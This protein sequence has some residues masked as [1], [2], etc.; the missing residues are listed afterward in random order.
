MT[1]K[2]AYEAPKLIKHQRLQKVTL[3]TTPPPL[4]FPNALPGE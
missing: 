2:M 3:A 4:N 1:A